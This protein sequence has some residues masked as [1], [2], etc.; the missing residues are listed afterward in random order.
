MSTTDNNKHRRT[1]IFGGGNESMF[2]NG[3]LMLDYAFKADLKF[4]IEIKS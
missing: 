1:Y 4:E 3:Y 2:E